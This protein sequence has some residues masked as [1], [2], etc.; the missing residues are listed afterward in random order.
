MFSKLFKGEL[1]LAA[2]FWKF[3]V[4]GLILL[5]YAL[6]MFASFLA[7]YLQGRTVFDFFMHHFHL[8]YTSKWSLW[9]ALC[10]VGT[11]ILFIIY[12]YKIIVAVW[13]AA[14]SYD[15][16][17]WLAQLAR[18]GILLTVVWVWYPFIMR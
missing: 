9:W 17:V 4:F 14:E 13:R 12:S 5:H 7:G 15:K 6:R 11:L 18:I 10:Y 1:S 16:S 3:G 2:T 8:V